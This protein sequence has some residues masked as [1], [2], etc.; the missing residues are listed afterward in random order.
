MQLT[1]KKNSHEGAALDSTPCRDLVGALEMTPRMRVL[2]LHFAG[3]QLR[4]PGRHTNGKRP[5]KM[6]GR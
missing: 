3:E 6:E 1:T 5:D 4:R 2:A